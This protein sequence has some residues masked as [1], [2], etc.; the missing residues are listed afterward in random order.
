MVEI[1]NNVSYGLS[2]S[3]SGSTLNAYADALDWGCLGFT[4]KVIHLKNTDVANALKYKLL[5]Y[6]YKDGNEY[7]EVSETALASG[8]TA[9]FILINAYAQVKLQVKSSV[10]SSHAT[11]EIDFT[12]NR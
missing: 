4:K 1:S 10:A 12:G 7:E 8:D 2:N 11:F 3:I 6:A 9:Q 5:T